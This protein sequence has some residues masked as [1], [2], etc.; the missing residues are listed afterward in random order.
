MA[1]SI[2][3]KSC[4]CGQSRKKLH[5]HFEKDVVFF[6]FVHCDKGLKKKRLKGQG[7][8]VVASV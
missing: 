8:F 5:L 6:G 4:I 1:F 7:C 2:S 3:S